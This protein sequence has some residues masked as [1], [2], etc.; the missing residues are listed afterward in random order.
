MCHQEELLVNF[1]VGPQNE[2]FEFLA[3]TGADWSSI[4]ELPAGVTIGKKVCEVM[5]A[6]GKPF[7][8]S[9]VEN[10]EIKGNLRQCFPD[11]TY[12]PNLESNLLGRDLQVQLEVGIIPKDGRMIVQIMRLTGDMEEI[13]PE[14]WAE[15]GKSDYLDIPPI[16]IEMQKGTPHLRVRQYPISPEGR[17]GLARVIEQLLAEGIL[18]PCPSL[19]NT[20]ILA[21]KKAEGRY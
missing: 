15:E 11:F 14:V 5:G 8:A 2:E 16:K 9:I 18:E 21:I 4:R 1:E 3:D 7:K 10:V 6:E 12:L 17:E 13:H 19:H 20:A